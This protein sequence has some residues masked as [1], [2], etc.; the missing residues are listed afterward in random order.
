MVVNSASDSLKN[1]PMGAR[2]I[3]IVDDNYDLADGLAIVLEDE[4]YQVVVA[5]SGEEGIARFIEGDFAAVFLDLKLPGISGI[6]VFREIRKQKPGAKVIIMT[7]FRVDQLLAQVTDK[8][9]VRVLRKPFTM[10]VVLQMLHEIQHAGIILLVD[11][12]ANIGKHI[13]AFFSNA[14][15]RVHVAVNEQQAMAEES[16]SI[17]DVLV[18]DLKQPILYSLEVYLELKSRGY[19]LPT[20]II[21]GLSP[22]ESLAMDTLYSMSVTGCLFKAF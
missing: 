5:Y 6:E 7:G 11:D 4:G 1:D 22:K 15:Y 10:D 20:I 18:L 2:R 21:T 14:N 17:A 3:L 9:S 13:K 19:R 16:L 8:E 12:D